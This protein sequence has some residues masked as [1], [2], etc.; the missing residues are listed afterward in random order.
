MSSS[1]VYASPPRPKFVSYETEFR[2]SPALTTCPSC[3]SQVTTQITYRS[4]PC[5]WLMCLV[6][7]LCGLVL[8]CCLIPFFVS[9]F[10]DAYHICPRCRRVLHTHKKTC[11]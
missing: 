4:G 7:I 5:T 10:K 2:R 6:F 1:L 8:G 3:Q 9:Y 11:Y